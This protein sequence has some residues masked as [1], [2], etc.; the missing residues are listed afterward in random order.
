MVL[1]PPS[2]FVRQ[3]FLWL[4]LLMTFPVF[5]QNPP[6][7]AQAGEFFRSGDQHYLSNQHDQA[8]T[9]Y[10]QAAQLYE[11]AFAWGGMVRCFT[12]MGS[13]YL[14]R[15]ELDRSWQCLD[16]AYQTGMKHLGRNT[17]EMAECLNYQGAWYREKGDYDQQYRLY[18]ES[19]KIRKS[20]LGEVHPTVATNYDDLGYY[21]YEQGEFQKALQL[22]QKS[23]N[24]YR[25]LKLENSRDAG[26]AHNNIGLVYSEIGDFDRALQHYLEAAKIYEATLGV[27]HFW[28]AVTYNN[29]GRCYDRKGEF[30]TALEYI[31]KGLDIKIKILGENSV[32]VASSYMAMATNL[33][34]R[35]YYDEELQHLR[36]ALTIY[37]EVLGPDH[38]Y[39]GTCYN[40]ISLSYGS[41][42]DY[43]KR[44]L[45]LHKAAGIYREALGEEHPYVGSTY[46][47]MAGSYRYNKNYEKA[48][49]Y[50]HKALA[51]KSK[52][53]GDN[54]P[55]KAQAQQG[56]GHCYCASGQEDLGIESLHKA[57]ESYIK[58]VGENHP[59]MAG[60]Y[61]QLAQCYK[62]LNR[63]DL[64]QSNLEKALVIS[65]K[66]HLTKHPEV[67]TIQR[68]LGQFY[69][70]EGNWGKALDH[71]Q[72]GLIHVTRSFDDP[73]VMSNPPLAEI[74]EKTTFL[75]L[76]ELK[77]QALE[78]RHQDNGDLTTLKFSLETFQLAS[79]WVNEL[80]FSFTLEKDKINLLRYYHSVFEGAIRVSNKLY[81]QTEEADY[82]QQAFSYSEK[83]KAVL[84]TE[85]LNH[86]KAR[87]FAGIPDSLLERERHLKT[88]LE[89]LE[90]KRLQ[91]YQEQDA[92]LGQEFQEQ[93]FEKKLAYDHLIEIFE[94][95]Y[96]RYYSLKY[97]NDN[98][99]IDDLKQQLPEDLAVV[100]YFLGKKNLYIFY[101]TTNETKLIERPAEVQP[102][103]D[104]LRHALE[105]PPSIHQ[106]Q[107]SFKQFANSAY[108]LYE[109]LLQPVLS[110]EEKQ[111]LVIPH[112]QLALI[113]FDVLINEA[114]RPGSNYKNLSYLINQYQIHYA[115][116]LG[117]QFQSRP[118]IK[119]A[120]E[121]NRLLAF[122]PMHTGSAQSMA[123]GSLATLRDHREKELPGALEEIQG[124]GQFFEGEYYSGKNASEQLFKDKAGQYDI[125]H[126]ATHS[127]TDLR[128]P[129]FSYL[130]FF[131]ADT[132]DEEDNLLYNYELHNLSLEASMVVLSACETGKG[133]MIPG[134]GMLSLGRGFL[135]A[136]SPSVITSLWKVEDH[137]SARI[138]TA[139]Y[140]NLAQG[141][142]K[143]AA[144]RNA[145][146]EF[147]QQADELTSHPFF[148]SG[149]V[150]I[151]DQQALESPNTSESN[152]LYIYLIILA[153]TLLFLFWRRRKTKI[154]A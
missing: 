48:L 142:T 144:L 93:R 137:S 33:A 41:M 149:F 119:E 143:D 45:Y 49:I 74:S 3:V 25:E 82:Q 91:A 99:R 57:R 80:R 53:L 98:F 108:A 117:L 4:L 40:N 44:L 23:L 83:S 42:G 145:K 20:L 150:S 138:M 86:S 63:R 129:L 75:R 7:T 127:N 87:H 136:G 51:I 62:N 141:S 120:S 95:E 102:H 10:R 77:A 97:S 64:V 110:Q 65:K 66:A 6:D 61:E 103:L 107:E 100:E 105:H 27:D 134:E 124:I 54:H 122:A 128:Q 139:F 30:E 112:G 154:S 24:I 118:I 52:K 37:L 121:K 14:D 131:D 90:K 94:K 69:L 28:T 125:I 72:Q 101:L 113:P 96:P 111:L 78:K 109:A 34:N 9:E 59:L 115:F 135:L 29:L 12:K 19:L 43:E 84:L 8:L 2:S 55:D 81:L 89:F 133:Q 13:I 46:F 153:L 126:L 130:T 18:S 17:L 68:E 152:F 16:S 11:Q 71:I 73:D 22:H 151:G 148:W 140:K 70:E 123:T 76:L 92:T 31:K 146:L 79:E 26:T 15:S 35:G 1:T 5:A 104:H 50:Y 47:N 88:D 85:S 147:I 56:I 32:Q 67:A 60:C 116:T 39:I 132:S 106:A 114:P 36:K 58:S 38:Y 21:Y